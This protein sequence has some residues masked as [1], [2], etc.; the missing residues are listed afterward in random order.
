MD[1]YDIWVF[2]EVSGS[3]SE[4]EQPGMETKDL[5]WH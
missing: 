1:C 5:Q 3:E 4:V 2:Q